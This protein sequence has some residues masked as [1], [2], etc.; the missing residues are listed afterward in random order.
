MS[1]FIVRQD[2]HSSVVADNIW[3]LRLGAGSMLIGA[4]AGLLVGALVGLRA[5]RGAAPVGTASVLADWSVNIAHRGGAKIAP[6]NTLLAFEHGL[7]AGAGVLE[8]DVHL[9]RDGHLVVIHDD[10]VNRTTDGSGRV[11]E[12]TLSE[13]KSLDAGYQFPPYGGVAHPYRGKGVTVPTLEEVYREFPDV[14]INVEIKAEGRSGAVEE[15]WRLIKEAGASKRT[16]VVSQDDGVIRRFRRI[17]SGKVA[18]GSSIREIVAFDLL[19]RLGLSGLLRPRY[20]ALQ[21]P[22]PTASCTW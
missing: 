16:L 17:T 14:P 12:M 8:L 7:K 15:V 22:K 9:T 19:S 20:Q 4:L 3:E 2:G 1:N 5:G 21:G 18:T 10:T 13:I 11:R 6:E